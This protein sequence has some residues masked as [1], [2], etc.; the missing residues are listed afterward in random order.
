M[1]KLEEKLKKVSRDSDVREAAREGKK[2]GRLVSQS[3]M[4]ERETLS[5]TV[6]TV[7][8]KIK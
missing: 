5:K 8:P 3:E 4:T 1:K 6:R 7:S 2:K